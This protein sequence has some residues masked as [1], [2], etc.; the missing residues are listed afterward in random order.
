MCGLCCVG[1]FSS[2]SFS[3][4]LGLLRIL[5]TS[6]LFPSS[7]DTLACIVWGVCSHLFCWQ[8]P[9]SCRVLT[10]LS[11]GPAR[12]GFL[13][14][15]SWCQPCSVRASLFSPQIIAQ[16]GA[17]L[18]PSLFACTAWMLLWLCPVSWKEWMR[19][20]REAATQQLEEEAAEV[21]SMVGGLESHRKMPQVDLKARKIFKGRS[22]HS[23]Q[24]V[25][26]PHP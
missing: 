19:R 6:A 17:D 5:E 9:S 23:P 3:P 4:G 24:F 22:T 26:S 25:F 21:R 14:V 16:H 13:L 18:F 1:S 20:E 8:Q 15:P 2:P 10:S 7:G 11:L 12:A